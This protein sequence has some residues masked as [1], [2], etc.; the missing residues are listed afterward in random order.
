MFGPKP[1]NTVDFMLVYRRHTHTHGEG[2][3]P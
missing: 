3:E 2:A 1:E